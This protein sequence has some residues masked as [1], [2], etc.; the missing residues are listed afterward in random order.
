MLKKILVCI[1]NSYFLEMFRDMRTC[2]L[3]TTH[4]RPGKEVIVTFLPYI[5]GYGSEHNY[6]VPHASGVTKPPLGIL[7]YQSFPKGR[8]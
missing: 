2:K 7:A 4:F 6:I 1:S 3:I 8:L 5:K